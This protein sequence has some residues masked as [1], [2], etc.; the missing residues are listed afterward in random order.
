MDYYKVLQVDSDAEPDVIE[1]AFRKLASK[2]HPDVNSDAASLGRMKALNR[3][4]DVLLDAH[5]R[6]EYDRTRI[7]DEENASARREQPR[8]RASD[9]THPPEPESR[10]EPRR[11]RRL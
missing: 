6:R 4:R 10:S 11:V 7:A 2:Y 5:A 9:E 1:A 3:A 8:P